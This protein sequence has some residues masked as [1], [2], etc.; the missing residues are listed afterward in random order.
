MIN[1][2]AMIGH[3]AMISLGAMVG[4][5]LWLAFVVSL[6]LWW[7]LELVIYLHGPMPFNTLVLASLALFGLWFQG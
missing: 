3:E 5:G 1:L 4:L 2:E 7:A 6:R